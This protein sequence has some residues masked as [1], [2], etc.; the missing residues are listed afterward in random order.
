MGSTRRARIALVGAGRMGRVHL[1]AMLASDEIELAG[2][3]EPAAA[4]REAL[5]ADGVETYA[6][7]DQLLERGDLDGVLIAAPTDRHTELAGILI[8]AGVPVLCEKPVGVRA[9]DADATAQAAREAGVLLQVGYWRRFV[10]ALR[11]LRA[12]IEAGELGDIYQL[13]CMQWDREPPSEDFR[14][15][16]GGIAIDMC[17]HEFD[18]TRWLLGQEIEWLTATT[19]GPDNGHPAN[20]PDA[21]LILAGLSG[22]TAATV[23]VGRR[24][25]IEDSCWVEVWGT[26]GH[27]RVSF[28]WGADGEQVFSAG[29]RTQ[30]ESFARAARGGPLEGADGADAV[31]ALNAAELAARSLEG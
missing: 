1:Q 12:R 2:V 25:P 8:S 22:G 10:P 20:D 19:A 16:S 15:H 28:M 31:A 13:S 6:E 14:A 3:V 29:M 4:V 18:Q 7:V 5:R 30:V 24:F 11:E 17:V 26:N 23:S 21:A 27:E 9:A